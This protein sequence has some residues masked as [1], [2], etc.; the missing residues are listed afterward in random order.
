MPSSGTSNSPGRDEA[1]REIDRL[2]ALLTRYQHE[3]YVANAPSVS[4]RE[5][6]RLFDQLVELETRFPELRRPDSPTQ[7][8]GSDLTQELPEVPH[9]IPVL[10]L[11]KA[12]T[13]EEV[14]SWVEKTQ[15]NAG[16]ELSFVIE[17]KIDGASIVLY[18]EE[19]LLTRAVTRGNGLVGNE[20]TANV[21][22]IGAVPLRLPRP[23]TLAARGEI[24]LTRE[25]FERVNARLETPYANPRNLASGTLHRVKSVEV[26]AVPLD[27]LVYEG[28]FSPPR[29]THFAVLEELEEL[30]FKIN[31]RT[32]FFSDHHDLAALRDR[33]PR[34]KMGS[35]AEMP[36][37][38]RGAR[39]ERE[40]RPYDTD[41]L[42]I[43]VN[44][45]SA[46]TA[47]GFTGHHPRWALAFKFE[48]PEA[49]SVVERI[50]VQV[51][52]T[53]RITPVARV[54]PVRL[55][56]STVSNAT[57][58]NQDYIDTL[59]LAVGD[60]VSVSKRGDVIPA[61][62]RVL[63]KNEVGNTTWKMPEAC[64]SCGTS[65]VRVGAHH[66]CPNPEC[67][68][69]VRG[70]LYFFAGRGQMDIEGLGPETIDLLIKRGLVRDID[71]LYRF[72][73]GE[74]IGV[75][76]FGE[77]KVALL[78]KGLDKSRSKPYRTV[79]VSLGI[80]EVGQKAAEL[81]CEAG[82]RSIDSLLQAADRGDPEPFTAIHGIGEKTAQT[83]ILTLS[84]PDVRRRI[85]GLREAGL[86]VSEQ[87]PE[88]G[89]GAAAGGAR[90]P[91]AGQSWCVTGSFE[92]F[93]PRELAMEEVKRRGGRVS[94][95]VTSRTTHLLAGP[96]AGSK[97]D[98]AR[99][100]GV[101]VVDEEQFLRLLAD[102][103]AQGR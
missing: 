26:A 94:S 75:A 28:Y 102:A 63:E 69:Q 10:S 50:E 12:Y 56:G 7:R 91:F 5:Y 70:R 58:H 27:I 77:K 88:G 103:D 73:P 68:D 100:L 2:S 18:Y 76:G 11:D 37:Y 43:K 48:A 23:V 30:G 31:R 22:T 4:D 9:T 82:Y 59:E 90:G 72:D 14:E 61:V 24:F 34:W 52:R 71:D 85:A 83:L 39:A 25:L 35:L 93:K 95:S 99:E 78:R 6:D 101:T 79:L 80:P 8:V 92:R 96:G 19:G 32:G 49:Q 42:V 62:E 3:Y 60:R 38:I 41:G 67:P 40:Q 66:F 89:E 53:G 46:R 36:E 44:E 16:L 15:R 87:A 45:I 55:S 33:H 64:P 13:T 1:A 57:L 84:R 97:L 74:L 47:L 29:E 81:L 86:N 65:L 54:E 98:K 17:E 20:V 21:R 51:G